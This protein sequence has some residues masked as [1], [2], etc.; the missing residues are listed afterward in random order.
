MGN[1]EFD[2]EKYRKASRHQK[3]W[4]NHLI[5][6]I[7]LAGDERILDLGCGDGL[8][9]EKIAQLVPEGSVLGIDASIGMIQTAKAME[10][11]NLKFIQMD[12]NVMDFREEFDII[13]SNAALHWVKD[14]GLLL[15]NSFQALKNGGS[16]YWNFAGKGTCLAFNSLMREIIAKPEYE[17]YFPDFEWPWV[18]LSGGQYEQMV[19]EAGFI[20][21]RLIEEN[22]DRY[23][24]DTDELVRWIDQP[25]IVPFLPNIPDERKAAF[26][27]EVIEH[28]IARTQQPDGTCF[29]T[30]RRINVCARKP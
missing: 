22:R 15:K 13:Y 19:R 18:M 10:K 3:E 17:P 4:G 8:L 30:F 29:E 6:Q 16:I 12:I 9:T 25:S 20:D 11:D 21:I 7:P 24:A 14:H 1:F 27:R 23:F 5:S 26:R 28:M 2:G